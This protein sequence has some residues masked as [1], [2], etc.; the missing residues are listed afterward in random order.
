AL[1]TM[2]G[3]GNDQGCGGGVAQEVRT[4][5]ESTANALKKVAG[6][7][8]KPSKDSFY[9]Y[10]NARKNLFALLPKYGK[11]QQNLK[12]AW[13]KLLYAVNGL[14]N[15][16]LKGKLKSKLDSKSQDIAAIKSEGQLDVQFTNE[17]KDVTK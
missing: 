3:N 7:S 11:A 8:G 12:E 6:A 9:G 17:F 14:Q 4:A 15:A 1:Q 2:C 10:L 5:T 13:G 16:D